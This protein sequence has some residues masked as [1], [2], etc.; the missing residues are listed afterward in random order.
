MSWREEW[1]CAT[2]TSGGQCVMISGTLLRLMLFVDSLDLLTL[3]CK[4]NLKW[5]LQ[6]YNPDPF[7]FRCHCL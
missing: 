3:V 6:N 7:M 4:I 5:P 1:K 2:T